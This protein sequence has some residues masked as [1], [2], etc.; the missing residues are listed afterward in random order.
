MKIR[1]TRYVE[2]EVPDDSTLDQLQRSVI[3]A[4]ADP[5]IQWAASWALV[6]GDGLNKAPS[7]YPKTRGL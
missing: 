2:I 7:E 6:N 3:N 1:I 4:I 5:S